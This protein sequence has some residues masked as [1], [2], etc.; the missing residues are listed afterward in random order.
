MAF[1]GSS[2]T[3]KVAR[4]KPPVVLKDEMM[5]QQSIPTPAANNPAA[6][7]KDDLDTGNNLFS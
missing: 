6:T 7:L 2:P 1:H 3:S 4:E 5:S